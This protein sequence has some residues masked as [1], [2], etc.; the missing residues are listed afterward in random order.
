MPRFYIC[1]EE[2]IIY[3]QSVLSDFGIP[4]QNQYSVHNLADSIRL[5]F[6]QNFTWTPDEEYAF[7]FYALNLNRLLLLSQSSPNPTETQT[8]LSKKIASDI[9]N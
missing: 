2:I 9:L 8:A 5:H 4:N 3:L 7:A 6:L 1:A